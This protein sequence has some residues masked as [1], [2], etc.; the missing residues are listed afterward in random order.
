[1]RWS[2]CAST[3]PATSRPAPWTLRSSPSTSARAPKAAE[4]RGHAGEAVGLLHP[5]LPHVAKHG[6]ARGA[7]RGHGQDGDL[8]EAGDLRRRRPRWPAA[9]RSG[10]RGRRWR[11]GRRARWRGPRRSPPPC[12]AA[13][14]GS[15]AG[16]AR[17]RRRSTVTSLSGTTQAATT[18]KAAC[19][20][21]P[22]TSSSKGVNADG[23]SRTT[24]VAVL[25][26]PRSTSAPQR[27]SSSSV[28]RRVSTGSRTTV[29]PSA[30]SAGEQHARL[31]LGAG[32]GRRVVDAAER[33]AADVSGGRQRS[34]RPSTIGPHPPQG[35]R[36]PG[37]W[38][39]STARRR[40]STR[41]CTAARPPPRPAAAWWC[42][43]CPTSSGPVAACS[44]AAPPRPDLARCR[45]RPRARPEGP[46]R[47]RGAGHVVAVGQPA[48]HRLARGQRAEQQGPVRDRLVARARARLPAR[49]RP[50]ATVNTGPLVG[51]R[52]GAPG[53]FEL[54]DGRPVAAPGE[55]VVRGARPASASTT[56]T[57]TPRSPST[58]WA[59][60]RS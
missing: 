34:V 52:A 46:H 31:H 47:R 36:P 45:R 1:M 23:R 2:P 24:C 19:D 7:G 27:A 40:R 53:S 57:S 14:R 26:A 55:A 41:S 22:G 29:S 13:R 48:Q 25:V 39:G 50:P 51:R 49:G 60:S 35:H 12:G 18:Q 16:P 44:A 15:R 28:W 54:P 38:A 20:G 21:S 10:R 4:Q 30:P 6:V 43:S 11:R 42:P 9:A 56:R 58:L 5:Q 37:P 3:V 32:H 59:I 33:P 8:V 17:R